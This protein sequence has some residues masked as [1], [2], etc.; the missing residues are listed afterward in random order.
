MNKN[1]KLSNFLIISLLLA[2]CAGT[3]SV[4]APGAESLDNMVESFGDSIGQGLKNLG[5]QL[6][7]ANESF[8]NEVGGQNN[9]GSYESQMR[10]Y[11]QMEAARVNELAEATGVSPDY[12]RQLRADGMTW[13]QIADKYG[14]NMDSLPAP[15]PN[16]L[17]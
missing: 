1:L 7:R 6:N 12:I 4:T 9:N 3:F 8:L 13:E 2:L 16:S 15:Q 10:L 17:P 14:V 5:Q 11:R